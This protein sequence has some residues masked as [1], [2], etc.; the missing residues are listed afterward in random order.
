[1]A[2]PPF[3]P[4]HA[5]II[6][7]VGG[8]SVSLLPPEYISEMTYSRKSTT[9]S[10]SDSND[11]DG[12]VSTED[13]VIGSDLDDTSNNGNGAGNE[14]SIT[15]HDDTAILLEEEI[16]NGYDKVTF[17]YGY[18]NGPVSSLYE[19]TITNYGLDFQ[20]T[21]AVL[22]LNCVTKGTSNNESKSKV[23]KNGIDDA[24]REIAKEENWE[25]GKLEPTNEVLDS[26]GELKTLERNNM[27]ATEFITSVLIP[28]STSKSTGIGG[29]KIW[30]TDSANKVVINYA[31]P[32]NVE[33]SD[34]DFR[35][36]AK[37]QYEWG[38]GKNSEVL[39]FSPNIES[40]SGNFSDD[41]MSVEATTLDTI[42]NNLYAFKYSNGNNYYKLDGS[43]N[44][45]AYNN[46]IKLN[47][48]SL[49]YSELKNKSIAMWYI[50]S[51]RQYEATL[52]ITGNPNLDIMD[53]ISI[54]MLNRYGLP[55]HSTGV[56]TITGIDDSISG[57]NFTTTL[58]L[59]RNPLSVST[60]N[61]KLVITV[62][63]IDS[64]DDNDSDDNEIDPVDYKNEFI[65]VVKEQRNNQ[66]SNIYYNLPQGIGKRGS[67][68]PV[69]MIQ[70]C[71]MTAD[72]PKS[73]IDYLTDFTVEKFMKYAKSGNRFY[74]ASKSYTPE[75]G[76]IIFYYASRKTNEYNSSK[77]EL[78]R[79][80]TCAVVTSYTKKLKKINY[81][82]IE[83]F[84]KYVSRTGTS[85]LRDNKLIVG[86]FSPKYPKVVKS[87]GKVGPSSKSSSKYGLVYPVPDADKS[88]SITSPYGPRVL[89]G[90][91]HTGIDIS[92]PGSAAG[93]TAIIAAQSGVVTEAIDKF[94]GLVY[95]SPKDGLANTITITNSK[96]G[97]A[98]VYGHLKGGSLKVKKGEKVPQGK[99][100]A[101]MGST[102][103]STGVHLHFEVHYKGSHQNPLNFVDPAKN[104][105]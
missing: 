4:F 38:T 34:A 104:R 26:E 45:V 29:Y 84:T 39:S 14:L 31:P 65:R 79:V 8:L 5:F 44:M 2:N 61:G 55:H 68:L 93:N 62:N 83:D 49:S 85:K 101:I 105:F 72:I 24:I 59:I 13:D 92:T 3:N 82:G 56:Y 9:F 103:W 99:V 91:F 51:N 77:S 67:D 96:T 73:S 81:T 28:I 86:F 33:E 54:T 48:S 78:D 32:Y 75:E 17:K 47:S 69:A 37:Y 7:E 58:S 50:M 57:G 16:R 1:M 80:L 27:S 43:G 25:V 10:N 87:S 98:T 22:T 36:K 19:C 40:I 100:I 46:P 64:G 97:I 11:D 94:P 12:E 70:W 60:E 21:G 6:L 63:E 71:A 102:G 52:E 88:G 15:L 20:S 53:K 35:T 95:Y 76:D 74:D 42:S 89:G 41:T 30:F 18:A 90:G 23:Y 66:N